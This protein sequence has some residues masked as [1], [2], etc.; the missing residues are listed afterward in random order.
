MKSLDDVP[1]MGRKAVSVSK[2]FRELWPSYSLSRFRHTSLYKLLLPNNAWHNNASAFQP[3]D[4]LQHDARRA[5]LEDSFKLINDDGQHDCAHGKKLE[6]IGI[7][8]DEPRT[9]RFSS[10]SN[11][12][13]VAVIDP[14]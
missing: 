14:D 7:S 11:F 12:D 4:P 13:V 8:F 2:T 3:N 10:S 9:V 6:N 5:S 1:V